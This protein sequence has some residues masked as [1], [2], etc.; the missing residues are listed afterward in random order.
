MS[1]TPLVTIGLPFFNNAALIR[2]AVRSVLNQTYTNWEL[3]LIDD[4]STDR[5]GCALDDLADS[6][7]LRR[8]HRENRGQTARL[9]EVTRCA[10]GRFIARMDAD[11]IMHPD[12]IRQQVEQLL[13]H[14]SVDLVSTACIVID[15]NNRIVGLRRPPATPMRMRDFLKSSHLVH[16]SVMATRE[17]FVRNPYDERFIRSQD[18]ELWCRTCGNSRFTQMEA[19]LLFYREDNANA[20]RNYRV[21][22]DE[23][24]QIIQIYGPA[25]IGRTR[26]AMRLLESRAK[27]ALYRAVCLAGAEPCWKRRR[28]LDL[29][30]DEKKGFR[31]ALDAALARK[32]GSECG[33][34][35]RTA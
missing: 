11:D 8:N 7:I 12:R 31:L 18:R 1:T 15:R 30:E 2:Q 32:D 33:A 14:P 34:W 35:T 29:S 27:E 3:L 5:A 21:H 16:P 4:G 28:N 22:S 17:F 10:R 23:D 19:P 26:T 24:R 6:R 20:H 13:N 9:N 25:V